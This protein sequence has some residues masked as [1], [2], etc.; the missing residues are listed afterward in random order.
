M[1]S[2]DQYTIPNEIPIFFRVCRNVVAEPFA[3]DGILDGIKLTDRLRINRCRFY[4]FKNSNGHWGN[5]LQS[6]PTLAVPPFVVES[7][8]SDGFGLEPFQ[9]ERRKLAVNLTDALF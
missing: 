6:Q 2:Y 8:Q 3:L 5:H 9:I 7:D 4:T 1:I